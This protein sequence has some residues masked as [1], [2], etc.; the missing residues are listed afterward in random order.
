MRAKK[1]TPTGTNVFVLAKT[2]QHSIF[3]PLRADATAA[4]HLKRCLA[5]GLCEVDGN[6]LRLTPEGMRA[7]AE[8]PIAC[9]VSTS[10]TRRVI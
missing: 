5:A 10:T 2:F 1:G 9:K 3:A 4:P 7:I 8:N 6:S